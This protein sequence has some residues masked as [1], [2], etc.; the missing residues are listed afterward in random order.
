MRHG[1]AP[2][3]S[4]SVGPI[5]DFARQLS[6]KGKKEAQKTAKY[7]KENLQIDLILSSGAPRSEDTAAIVHSQ[8]PIG[9]IQTETVIYDGDIDMILYILNSIDNKHR[10]VCIVGHNPT[11]LEFARNLA[12]DSGYPTLNSMHTAKAIIFEIEIDFWNEL[13]SKTANLIGSF[14]P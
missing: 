13:K 12:I 6:E 7:L 3:S 8:F 11:I 1:D 4:N 10:K 14:C 2:T 5:S 9:D